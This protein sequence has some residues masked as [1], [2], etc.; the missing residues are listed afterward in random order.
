VKTGLILDGSRR[1]LALLC[2]KA[3][4]VREGLASYQVVGKVMAYQAYDG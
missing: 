3:F 1:A 4:V 2:D